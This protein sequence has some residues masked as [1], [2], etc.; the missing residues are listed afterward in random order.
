MI[1]P[2][3]E[4]AP[5]YDTFDIGADVNAP[6][7]AAFRE[8]FLR[9]FVCPSDPHPNRWTLG[10]MEFA[11]ANYVGLFGT[12]DPNGC[13][14]PP[15]SPPVRGNGQCV[16]DGVFAHNSRT[17]IGRIKDGMS[18]TFLAGERGTDAQ[19][20]I[21]STWAGTA[22][23]TTN[24]FSR[25]VG[26]ASQPPSSPPAGQSGFSSHHPQGVHF[27]FCDGHVDFV[28][29]NIDNAVYEAAATINAN[30]QAGGF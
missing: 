30:D 26:S 27:V 10:N 16:G 21:F 20:G 7:N 18:N 14:S 25:I 8:T 4:Q 9:S 3:I 28:S 1:L 22:P 24:S 6:V 12:G 13:G 23:G 2:Q 11:T 5:L 17:S 15:G 19:Q 29:E